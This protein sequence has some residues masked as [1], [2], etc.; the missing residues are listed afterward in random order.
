MGEKQKE[1]PKNETEEKKPSSEEPKKNDTP[2]PVVYKLDLH[3]EGCIKKI[4]R[5]VRHFDGVED[6]KADLTANKLTVTGNDV[7]AVKLQEKLIVRTKKKV[8]LLTPPPPKKEAAPPPPAPPAEGEKK[9]DEK[10]PPKESTVVL[11]IRLHCDGCITKIRRIIQKFNGVDSVS[12][13][14]G[15]DLVTVK[16][17]MDVK[18][19]VPYLNDKL[20]RNVEVVA[21]KK[22]EEK[23][24]KDGGDAGAGEKKES[25][26][27]A[28]DKKDSGDKKESRGGGDGDK[29]E[30]AAATTATATTE[31][32]SEVNKME[33]HGYPLPSPIYWHN[34]NENFHQGQTSYAM[35]V[36]PGY[37]NHGY[38]YMEPP[39]GYMTQGYVMNH[40]QG[41]HHVEPGP[42]PFYMNPNQPHPQMFSDENPNACSLM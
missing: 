25:K 5:T 12:I 34:N 40:N 4:K 28:D 8:E 20:K 2:A 11:K 14:G 42:L 21:P 13:D 17:T 3:C 23:K 7:D 9:S 29:K 41:Y 6:V 27:A 10:K 32:K 19:L 39:Q 26:E 15:K 18:E 24:E 36:H 22:D 33:Y 1:Q 37:A 38:H 30:K 31:T 16:G 35:E